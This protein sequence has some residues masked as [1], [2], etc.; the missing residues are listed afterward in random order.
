M[1]RTQSGKNVRKSNLLRGGLIVLAAVML[2]CGTY[3]ATLAYLHE[4]TKDT[5][6]NT[7]IPA[8]FTNTT[9][10]IEEKAHT[11]DNLN[12]N[13]I[14]DE[15]GSGSPVTGETFYFA[16]GVTLKKQ[17]YVKITNLPENAYLFITVSDSIHGNALADKKELAW[18]VDTANWTQ[19]TDATHKRMVYVY[20]GP[21]ATTGG[22]LPAGSY[23]AFDGKMD[24]I[25]NDTVTVAPGAYDIR[26]STPDEYLN[27][28]ITFSAYLVQAIGFAD[29]QA[30]WNA[31]YG[32]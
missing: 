30:A 5:V 12:N 2:L 28:A 11:A 19:I 27:S 3:L 17:P 25:L 4:S 22:I 20:V 1:E 23:T 24:I 26:E 9:L 8:S 16:P 31:T 32:K 14:Y 29:S 10:T 6:H 7:F 13:G 15:V 21:H 18:Q